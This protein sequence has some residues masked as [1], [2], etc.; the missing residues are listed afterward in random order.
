MVINAPNIIKNKNKNNAMEY[1][2][3]AEVFAKLEKT[4]ER[5]KKTG[6]LADFLL[7]CDTDDI[8]PAVILSQ[9]RVFP[10]WSQKEIG[11]AS[12]LMV[13][14]IAKAYGIKGTEVEKLWQKTGDLGLAAEELS[15]KRRQATLFTKPLTVKSVHEG[16]KGLAEL[17]G[18]KSQKKKL[19][20][21]SYLLTS[22]KDVEAKYVVRAIIGNLRIGVADGVVRDAIAKAFFSEVFWKD[23]LKQKINQKKRIE[24]ILL[25]EKKSILIAEELKKTMPEV[26]GLEEN[27]D[28][29][30]LGEKDI[31]K[32]NDFWKKECK[33]DIVLV[34]S[35]ETGNALRAKITGI[36]EKANEAA[37][38][39]ALVAKIAKKEGTIGLKK[40]D[41]AVGRPIKVMLAQKAKGIEDAF[42]TVGKPCAFEYKYDG[43]RLQA[44][45]KGSQVQLYTRRLEDVTKQFPDVSGAIKK[46]IKA[47]S[48]IIEGEAVGYDKKTGRSIPFQ[49]ISRRIKRKY[50]IEELAE[51]VPVVLNLFDILSLDGITIIKEPFHKRRAHLEKI[52]HE[53]PKKLVVAEATVTDNIET[54]DEFYKKSLSLGNEGLMAKN[55]K[56]P[57]KPGSRV[58]HMLKIKPV[59]ETLDLTIVAADWGEGKRAGWLSSYGLACRDPDTGE[60]LT[61]GKLGTGIKEKKEEGTS[62]EE[63]TDEL[64]KHIIK[65]EAKR[66][67]IAPTI[68]VE[69]AY[70][71]IQK[72]ST[73]TA[74]FA[75]RFPRFVRIRDEKSVD[76][77][78]DI[79]KV[80][81]I[82]DS[83]RHNL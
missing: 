3:L 59:L 24:D 31:L 68:V 70:E 6:I 60:F 1:N 46:G 78:D 64:K 83:Q 61:M 12:L 25:L 9:G 14:A 23:I 40:I 58:G 29:K 39:F 77:I 82:F 62:F 35:A 32:I 80:I 42:E 11:V 63:I 49:N 28:V 43:F 7:E 10:S 19:E 56:A 50:N 34:G 33:Y 38:D 53:I 66:V 74:G 47:E 69:V 27:N 57:Y 18:N 76:E 16:L 54:A 75:L 5:L 45:K 13:K 20:I 48:C 26:C 15:K 36:V 67:E 22:A 71:E 65:K 81:A 17:E 44:H 8:Y 51:A 2:I 52:T 55:L 41:I 30:Y 72:S 79:N 73:Y 37:N 21:I 4:A